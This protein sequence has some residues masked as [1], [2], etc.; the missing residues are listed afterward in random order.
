MVDWKAIRKQRIGDA[1]KF[2]SFDHMT[3]HVT[4]PGPQRAALAHTPA[5][6]FV[7]TC[8]ER[9]QIVINCSFT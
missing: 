2:R 4:A 9:R 5:F 3:V 8:I 6:P 1:R 7:H